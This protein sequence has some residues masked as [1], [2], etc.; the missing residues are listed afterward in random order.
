MARCQNPKSLANLLNLS[1]GGGGIAVFPL[2]LPFPFISC[3]RLPR[4]TAFSATTAAGASES[5][6]VAQAGVHLVA[7]AGIR[8]D[9]P[10]VQHPRLAVAPVAPSR[11]RVLHPPHPHRAVHADYAP[12]Q[13]HRLGR[14]HPPARALRLRSRRPARPRRRR[15][16]HALRATQFQLR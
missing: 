1:D 12:R 13:L 4:A 2:A 8:A 7:V 14:P 5:A 9:L 10:V 11:H 16:L 6:G 15:V 3:T